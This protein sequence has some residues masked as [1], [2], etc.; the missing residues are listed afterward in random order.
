MRNYLTIL[1]A[2]SLVGGCLTSEEPISPGTSEPAS[3]RDG[4]TIPAIAGDPPTAV[5]HGELYNFEPDSRDADD[6]VLVFTIANKPDW[7]QFDETTGRLFGI[8]TLGHVGVY[9]NVVVGATD[10]KASISLP[11]FTITVSQAALGAVALSW[12]PPT[13]NS[14][15][16]P[17]VDLAGYKIFYGTRPKAYDHEIH[18][19]APGVTTF[20]VE[21][22]PPGTYY[23]AATS[24]TSSG[25]ES[26]YSAETVRTVE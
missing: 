14:D 16:S 7:A 5:L 17:L 4:N 22:L 1:I 9:E 3:F 2:G 20:L 19:S 15:G 24:F 18:V 25:I 10:S 8:P 6:D 11:A 12:L 26:E 21:D 23:F 13:E